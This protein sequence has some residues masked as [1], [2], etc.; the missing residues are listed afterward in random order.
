MAQIQITDHIKYNDGSVNPVVVTITTEG[1]VVELFNG[2]TSLS[3]DQI[4]DVEFLSE[5]FADNTVKQFKV[6][7]EM[8]GKVYQHRDMYLQML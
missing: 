2:P 8:L 3:W 6:I 4:V 5:A 1:C 7:V